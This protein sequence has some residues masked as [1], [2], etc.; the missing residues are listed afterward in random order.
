VLC[1]EI[2]AAKAKALPHSK[3]RYKEKSLLS[4]FPPPPPLP[5]PHPCLIAATEKKV[6]TK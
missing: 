1:V 6:S 2:I 4:L 5:L 3:F